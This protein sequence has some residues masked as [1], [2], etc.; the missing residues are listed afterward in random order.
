M[1]SK[2]KQ[3][4]KFDEQFFP[5]YSYKE[6]SGFVNKDEVF[7]NSLLARLFFFPS[8]SSIMVSHLF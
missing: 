4:I 5:L 3:K 8:L 6:K 7:S 1:F 2:N